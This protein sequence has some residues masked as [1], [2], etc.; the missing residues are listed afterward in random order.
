MQLTLLVRRGGHPWSR[1]DTLEQDLYVH[2]Q[3]YTFR[4]L[5]EILS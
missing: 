5:A 1:G 4:I 3:M 2:A